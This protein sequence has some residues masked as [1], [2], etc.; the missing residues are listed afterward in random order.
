MSDCT[1]ETCANY[2]PKPTGPRIRVTAIN[3]TGKLTK[4]S[5][6]GEPDWGRIERETIGAGYPAAVV[7]STSTVMDFSCASGWKSPLVISRGWAFPSTSFP[8]AHEAIAALRDRIRKHYAKPK[9]AFKAGDWVVGVSGEPFELNHPS[10][11]DAMNGDGAMVAVVRHAR[12]SDFEKTVNG[13]TVLLQRSK[14]GGVD[15]VVKGGG[16]TKH[17]VAAGEALARFMGV[18]IAPAG[19]E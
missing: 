16:R 19:L 1:C 18:T 12:L 11:A 6:R 4:W 15:M 3:K 13:T 8:S 10:L 17:S 7:E 5:F 9:P 14:H 2:A